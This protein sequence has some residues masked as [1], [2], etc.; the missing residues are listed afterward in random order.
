MIT[1]ALP[2][3]PLPIYGTGENVRD[4]IFVE[5]NCQAIRLVL[6]KGE[7]GQVYNVGAANEKRNIDIAKEIVRC[8]SL[9]ETMITFIE[10]RPGHDYR[11]SLDC[12]KIH[13]L[14]RK[15]QVAF[16][17]GLQKTIR[18]YKANERLWRPLID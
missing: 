17:E 15:P 1:N 11:Y 10:D 18:W 4:W 13:Q 9:P 14:G 7:K 16:E 12:D 8:L 2:R 6:E 3:K 5:D